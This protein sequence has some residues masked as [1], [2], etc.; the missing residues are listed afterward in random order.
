MT[1]SDISPSALCAETAGLEQVVLLNEEGEAIGVA[2]KRLVHHPA[3]PLHLAFS[4]YVFNAA[5]DLLVTQRALDKLT[6]PGVWTNTACGHPAPGEGFLAGVRRR[7]HDELG[8]E[9]QDLRV[10]LPRFRYQAVMASGVMENEICPVTTALTLDDPQVD[11]A[12]V[13]ATTWVPWRLFRD[14]VITGRRAVS[15]WCHEQVHQ[16][17]PLADDPLLWSGAPLDQLPPAAQVR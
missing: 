3:T 2:D 4:C 5:G 16:L 7:T 14:D 10:V 15:S 9:L 6:F 17:A 1:P 13:A 8:I 11:P 12:E